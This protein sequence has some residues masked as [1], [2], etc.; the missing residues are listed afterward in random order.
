MLAV[1]EKMRLRERL[2]L[3]RPGFCSGQSRKVLPRWSPGAL[4]V[5]GP[6]GRSTQ[7]I[8][9]WVALGPGGMVPGPALRALHRVKHRSSSQQ[10]DAFVTPHHRR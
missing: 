1:C 9:C 5:P 8:Q 10:V 6:A 7:V 4:W 3:A 2:G